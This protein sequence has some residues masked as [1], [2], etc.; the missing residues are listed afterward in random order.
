MTSVAL[1][2]KDQKVVVWTQPAPASLRAQ[3]GDSGAL[4]AALIQL[5]S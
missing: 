2:Q 3:R 5:T 4:V 1:A